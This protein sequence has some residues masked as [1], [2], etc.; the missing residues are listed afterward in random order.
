MLKFGF[1]IRKIDSFLAGVVL[2]LCVG[3]MGCAGLE[4]SEKNPSPEIQ[5]LVKK[6]GI[7]QYTLD[8]ALMPR[9]TA[10][11]SIPARRES[12]EMYRL[13]Q[14]RVSLEA[15]MFDVYYDRAQGV[16]WVRRTTASANL[17]EIF[18]PIRLADLP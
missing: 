3:L 14:E 6:Y 8:V 7:D 1:S 5:R 9:W 17:E 18:G 12:R 15:F 2:L 10:T 16:F 4:G 11:T 13:P